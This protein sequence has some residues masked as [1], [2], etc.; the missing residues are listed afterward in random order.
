MNLRVDEMVHSFYA[1]MDQQHSAMIVEVCDADLEV[2][3]LQ[4][5]ATQGVHEQ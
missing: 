5:S 1:D 3:V 2:N 4:T